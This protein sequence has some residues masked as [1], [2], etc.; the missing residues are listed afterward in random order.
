MRD[1]YAFTDT[2]ATLGLMR[3][4]RE[5]R[6]A[7]LPGRYR[8]LRLGCAEI[9][10]VGPEVAPLLLAHVAQDNGSAV[11]LETAA[12]LARAYELVVARGLCT[13]RGEAFDVRETPDSPALTQLDRGAVPVFGVLAWGVHLNGIVRRSDGL[14]LW[15]ARRAR[16]KRLDPGKLDHVVAGGAPA[17]MALHEV[18]AKEAEEEAGL[19]GTLI[20]SAQR[21]ATL[22][23]IMD[24]PE[25]L[26][27]DVIACYDL[28]LP[29]AVQP[30]P[31]DGEVES[32]ELWPINEVI[33][34]VQRTDDFKFNVNLVLIDLFLRLGLVPEGEATELRTALHQPGW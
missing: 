4:I 18:L 14:H 3:H 9:G 7:E 23:Y 24:R 25:G 32:F 34:R 16:D 15:V 33:D 22:S 31:L 21:V 10:W 27:R 20:A 1:P 30:R 12:D 28:V 8:P 26:R 11:V 17:G 29:E 19:S 6:N 13:P 2:N 5:C